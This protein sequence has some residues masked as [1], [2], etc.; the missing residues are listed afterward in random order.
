MEGDGDEIVEMEKVAVVVEGQWHTGNKGS[1]CLYC[2]LQ[3]KRKKV[4]E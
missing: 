1:V 4:V 2:R 3:G